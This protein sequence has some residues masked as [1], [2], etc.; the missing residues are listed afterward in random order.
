[1][2][3]LRLFLI[4]MILFLTNFFIENELILADE[5][6]KD[7]LTFRKANGLTIDKSKILNIKNSKNN[8]SLGIDL[9]NNEYDKLKS[10]E[11]S[12]KHISSD[13]NKYFNEKELGSIIID[14]KNNNIKVGIIDKNSNKNKI[15]LLK[16][17]YGNK[18]HFYSIKN[19]Y[20][21]LKN[22]QIQF[23]NEWK[24]NKYNIDYTYI[25]EKINK[26]VI[27]VNKNSILLFNE[28]KTS[29]YNNLYKVEISKHEN[30][31]HSYPDRNVFTKPIMAG[32]QIRESGCTAAY[33]YKRN[34]SYFLMTAGHCTNYGDIIK[35]G[36]TYIGKTSVSKFKTGYNSDIAA[37][38]ID[39]SLAS[40]YLWGT[41]NGVQ[42]KMA[43]IQTLDEESA[44]LK[45]K[46]GSIVCKSG[47]GYI[48]N[49]PVLDGKGTKCGNLITN[50]YAVSYNKSTEE[51]IYYNM[52]KASYSSVGGD[53]GAPVFS[54][55][56]GEKKT[57]LG[58]NSGGP[59]DKVNETYGIYSH[60]T[61]IMK[62]LYFT[63]DDLI[64]SK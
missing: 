45:D 33:M 31:T 6:S 1:M 30:Q 7:D 46:P 39:Q 47:V 22:A 61:E 16:L 32:Q 57:I 3:L 25:D 58:V 50:T 23:N 12:E 29:K 43:D 15:E 49:T 48:N 41:T 63:N 36:N 2:N 27:G 18:L 24:I 26:V 28:L 59:I 14:H 35:I 17:K 56:S 42:N 55:F 11:I 13:L 38:S 51:V 53:S 34:T 60:I 19:S 37:I 5:I 64:I 21:D 62:D 8:N 52:R 4:F 40:S 44:M 10:L 54:P 9:S 20:Q